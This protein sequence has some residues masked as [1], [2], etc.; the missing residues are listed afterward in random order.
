MSAINSALIK[1]KLQDNFEDTNF[2]VE[3]SDSKILI[4]TDAF[5]V[6]F[7]NVDWSQKNKIILSRISALLGKT[8]KIHGRNCT[9]KSID[10][11]QAEEFLNQN[12]LLGFANSYH[13][14]GLYFKDELMAV[15]TF[16]K[17]RKM[18]R[19]PSDKK[20]FE[21]VRFANK[22]FTIVVGGLSKLLNHFVELKTP[23]DIM[24]Y[25]DKEWSEGKSFIKLGFVILEE[26]EPLDFYIENDKKYLVKHQMDESKNIEKISNEGNLKL[27][28][29]Y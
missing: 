24:T 19:L 16:S 15:A 5:S 3:L 2:D 8:N 28:K 22:N 23:G 6:K 17:G 21:L 11:K 10:K 27:V 12:H 20:S 26:T 29:T 13:K 18:N 7:W 25:I 1:N 14:F 9:I 4:S